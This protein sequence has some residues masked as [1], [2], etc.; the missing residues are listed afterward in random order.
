M[1]IPACA[2][3]GKTETF[4][5]GPDS[6]KA[7]FV[8]RSMANSIY[9]VGDEPVDYIY[10]V[11]AYYTGNDTGAIAWDDPN[12]AINWPVSEPVISQRDRNSPR[13]RDLFPEKFE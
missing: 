13:L 3:F 9:M 4:I 6:S 1:K 7:L 10:M 8:P 2:S 12:L 5:F 11:D